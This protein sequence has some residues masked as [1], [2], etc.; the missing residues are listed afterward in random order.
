MSRWGICRRGSRL[1]GRR[2]GHP[3]PV[4]A[5]AL[6]LGERVPTA[7]GRTPVRPAN[8]R[9]VESSSRLARAFEPLSHGPFSGRSDLTGRTSL[10][11]N[12]VPSR[13]P[14]VTRPSRSSTGVDGRRNESFRGSR[15]NCMLIYHL[16]DQ[17]RGNWVKYN[18]L[19]RWHRWLRRD[20]VVSG[21]EEITEGDAVRDDGRCVSCGDDFDVV[22]HISQ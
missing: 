6:D 7:S 21:E 16:C 12:L 9:A 4:T 14:T 10:R 22:H 19:A 1:R 5:V 17:S 2:S 18:C 11:S 20:T 13:P 3:T 8:G 15:I